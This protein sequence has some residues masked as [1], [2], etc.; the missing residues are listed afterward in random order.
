VVRALT[1]RGQVKLDGEVWEARGPAGIA[2]G[3][4]VVVIAVE[5]LVLDVEPVS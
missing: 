1:P 5:G 3:E 2:P 4:E